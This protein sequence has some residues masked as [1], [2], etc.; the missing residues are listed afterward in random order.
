MAKDIYVS[1]VGGWLTLLIL[2]FMVFG[3]MLGIGQLHGELRT[4][5]GELAAKASWQRFEQVAWIILWCAVSV[6][7]CAGYRL[8]KTHAPESVKFA[9]TALWASEP[10]MTV[11][12]FGCMYLI[13]G[14]APLSSFIS[15]LLPACISA[16]IWTLYLKKSVRVHNTYGLTAQ[17]IALN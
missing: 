10:G 13:F 8:W 5:P 14:A 16:F 1:G 15:I 4:V 2:R 17:R 3:P 7:F 9:I 11:V 6:G 12:L